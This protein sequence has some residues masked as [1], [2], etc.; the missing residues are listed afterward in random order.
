MIL[1]YESDVAYILT[2]VCS[3]HIRCAIHRTMM[4]LAIQFHILPNTQQIIETV[5]IIAHSIVTSETEPPLLKES[6]QHLMLLDLH[7]KVRYGFL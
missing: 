3:Q 5:R 1:S 6:K 4:L 7:I 2:H